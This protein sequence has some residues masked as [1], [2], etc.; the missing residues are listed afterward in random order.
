MIFRC[1]RYHLFVQGNAHAVLA[2]CHLLHYYFICRELSAVLEHKQAENNLIGRGSTFNHSAVADDVH[3]SWLLL[4]TVKC[5]TQ[6]GVR[7]AFCL[8][9]LSS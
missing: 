4:F 5:L 6:P 9:T 1:L 2:L 8:Q 7:G 3:L